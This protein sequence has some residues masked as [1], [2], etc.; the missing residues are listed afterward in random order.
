MVGPCVAWSAWVYSVCPMAWNRG[1]ESQKGDNGVRGRGR[2]KGRGQEKGLFRSLA[3]SF[4]CPCSHTSVLYCSCVVPMLVCLPALVFARG[5]TKKERKTL[6]PHIETHLNRVHQVHHSLSFS[7]SY[8]HRCTNTLLP[9]KPR[10]LVT[11]RSI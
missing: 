8:P 5:R 4:S 10:H 11:S 7:P 1:N 6:I 2:T 3:Y 9:F